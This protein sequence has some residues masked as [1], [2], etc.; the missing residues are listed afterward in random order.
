LII[1]T[2]GYKWFDFTGI[3]GPPPTDWLKETQM[4]MV[5]LA[6]HEARVLES[7]MRGSGS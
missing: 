4:G 2:Q 7:K 1:K 5:E 3:A 6:A